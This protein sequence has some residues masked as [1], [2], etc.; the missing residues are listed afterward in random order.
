MHA[1]AVVVAS[2]R[3]PKNFVG[4]ETTLD[5]P[6]NRMKFQLYACLEVTSGSLHTAHSLH[7]QFQER[8]WNLD[9]E[10][11]HSIRLVFGMIVGLERNQ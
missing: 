3:N 2:L 8:M 7:A 5:G 9:E 4:G 10:S 6:Q 1:V 11:T